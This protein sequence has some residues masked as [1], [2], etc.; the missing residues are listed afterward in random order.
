MRAHSIGRHCRAPSA[1]AD[2]L[3]TVVTDEDLSKTID[4]S[5]MAQGADEESGTMTRRV[6]NPDR[7][8]A[9]RMRQVS[10]NP[11]ALEYHEGGD[12]IH[13]I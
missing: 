10:T 11:S 3:S 5:R 8:T 1:I 4:A 2:G 13:D 12:K 9:G 7:I 6:F